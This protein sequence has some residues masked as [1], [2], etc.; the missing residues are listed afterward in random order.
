MSDKELYADLKR[1]ADIIKSKISARNG[2]RKVYIDNLKSKGFNSIGEVDAYIRKAQEEQEK[3]ALII[4]VNCFPKH[5][6]LL[7][8]IIIEVLLMR[9]QDLIFIIVECL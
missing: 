7:V 1:R 2:E 3:K 6:L 5:L 8:Q 4:I 9:K